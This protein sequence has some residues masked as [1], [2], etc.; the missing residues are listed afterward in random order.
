MI[1]LREEQGCRFIVLSSRLLVLRGLTRN[2]IGDLLVLILLF[3][4]TLIESAFVVVDIT[5]LDESV[6]FKV[7]LLGQTQ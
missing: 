2:E 4:L 3:Y 1:G 7:D 6:M 5:D